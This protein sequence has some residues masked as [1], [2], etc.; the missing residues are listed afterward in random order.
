MV[1]D[2]VDCVAKCA[3]VN[4]M[5]DV[6]S[7]RKGQMSGDTLGCRL[8][9]ATSALVDPDTYCERAGLRAVGP[10]QEAPNCESFCRAVGVACPGALKVYDSDE[11]CLAV[12]ANTPQGTKM[13]TGKQDTVGCRIAHVFNA[14]LVNPEAHCPHI[15]PTGSNVC[16]DMV[17]GNCEAYCR[18]ALAACHDEYQS[19]FGDDQT[20]IDTCLNS[21]DGADK[22]V[23]SVE[24]AS[25][26]NTVQ[27]RAHAAAVA[28]TLP[29]AK[30]DCKAVFGG[31]PCE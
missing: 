19:A 25:S 26:G 2:E 29:V 11:Q 1:G 6:Y 18:L 16:G 7:W 13:D 17:S 15:G 21:I 31:A 24:T 3:A 28:L 9:Y 22:K 23:Y 4:P 30:R 5:P 8:Y 10:C 12:C 20:C 27:C 14:L